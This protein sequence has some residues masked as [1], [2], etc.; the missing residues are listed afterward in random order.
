[1]RAGKK[2]LKSLV[3]DTKLGALANLR[4]KLASYLYDGAAN[5]LATH[6]FGLLEDAV[7]KNAQIAKHTHISTPLTRG[8]AASLLGLKTQSTTFKDAIPNLEKS[9]AVL[10]ACKPAKLSVRFRMLKVGAPANRWYAA[11]SMKRC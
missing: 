6:L 1:M 7:A 11:N 3:A 4:E 5:N 9:L 8:S 10:P 2:L